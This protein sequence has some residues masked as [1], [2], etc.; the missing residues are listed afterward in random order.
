[1]GS[2][3]PS[4]KKRIN[5]WPIWV[6]FI[7]FA[8]SFSM[9]FLSETA[10]TGVSVP[11]AIFFLFCLILLGILFDILGVAVT[12]G[13]IIAYNAMAAKKIR[14]AKEAIMLIKKASVISNICNDV[15]GD[16]CGIVSGAM[17]A[18]IVAT[19]IVGEGSKTE[20]MY[21]VL[22]SSMTAAMTVSGKAAGKTIAM[23]YSRSIVFFVGKILS[24]FT[25]SNKKGR[26]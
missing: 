25:V 1:M 7:T 16:I 3:K 15:I 8:I 13:D 20:L 6:F 19:L 23:K 2:Q 22:I 24:F 10:L 4:K 21:S 9:S 18:A 17:G 11:I 5:T 12:S 14:G 26:K